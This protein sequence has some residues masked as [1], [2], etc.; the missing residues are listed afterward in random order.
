MKPLP[1]SRMRLITG[2][3]ID[4]DQKGNIKLANGKTVCLSDLTNRATETESIKV[5]IHRRSGYSGCRYSPKERAWLARANKHEIAER[6]KIGIDQARNLRLT[7]K[8]WCLN[9][10][11]KF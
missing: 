6:Y 10:N 9:K 4:Y 8:Y 7:S 11:I 2:E 1:P 5:G 3:I